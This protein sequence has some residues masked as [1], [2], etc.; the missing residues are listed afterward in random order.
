[1]LGLRDMNIPIPQPSTV[2]TCTLNNGIHFVTTPECPF[3][4]DSRIEQEFEL[5]ESTFPILVTLWDSS[6]LPTR[7]EHSKLEF[8][9]TLKIRRDPHIIAQFKALTH[10]PPTPPP[11]APRGVRSFFLSS[12]KKKEKVAASQQ[13]RQLP[14]NLARYLKPDGTLARAFISFKDIAN[15]CD[16]KLFETTYPLIGQRAEV[17][18]TVSTLQIGELVLQIFRLPP[19][20]G[21][22]LDQLPQSLEE[23]HRGLRH[24]NWHK[25]TYFEGTLTQN[26][27]DCMVS[28]IW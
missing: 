22:S 13:P 15:R 11:A 23:C 20:P 2:V 27:G 7:I 5:Y 6:D 8:T 3:G 17:G 18:N 4:K 12:P 9:L 28:E 25:V 1:V 10:A 26:G 16:S 14:E 24:V 21:V 19:L